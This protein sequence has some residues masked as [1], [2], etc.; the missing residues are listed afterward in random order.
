MIYQRNTAPKGRKNLARGASPWMWEYTIPKQALQGRDIAGAI[1]VPSFALAGLQ[2]VTPFPPR[3]ALPR[4]G[5]SALPW[6]DM[7]RPLR[8][9]KNWCLRHEV[10]LFNK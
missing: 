3:A 10:A 6:A 2:S 7:L 1:R 5:E 4:R 8:G 9:E